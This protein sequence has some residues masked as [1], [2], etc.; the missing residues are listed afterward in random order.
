MGDDFVIIRP[1]QEGDIEAIVGLW[2]QL[3]AYHQQLD[4]AMPVP[5]PDGAAR[6]AY[7]ITDSLR[8]AYAKTVVA[9]DE[10]RIIGYITAMIYDMMPEVF[11][12]E[13][14]G[15][16]GDIYVVPES[17]TQGV[18]R[19]LVESVEAWFRL[20]GVRYYEWYTATSNERGRAFWYGVGGRSLMQRMRKTL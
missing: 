12:S 13:L 19:A 5:A 9:E 10:G 7:R 3:V 14:A 18:G 8:D 2:Q 6:Y 20:R 16:V 11:V 1:A 15:M 4:S 17:R